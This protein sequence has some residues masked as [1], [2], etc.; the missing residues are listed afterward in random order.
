[1]LA[2]AR[3]HGGMY[4][5]IDVHIGL[6]LLFCFHS[7]GFHQCQVDPWL[8][9]FSLDSLSNFLQKNSVFSSKVCAYNIN[10][11]VYLYVYMSMGEKPNI[12]HL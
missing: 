6:H 7:A 4:I 10:I 1:M 9:K 8:P 3:I 12:A 11:N 2:K 5:W